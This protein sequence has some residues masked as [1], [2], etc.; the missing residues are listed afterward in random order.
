ML[1]EKT[2]D[3]ILGV[4]ERTTKYYREGIPLVKAYQKSVKEVADLYSI[5]YQTIADGCRRR[6]NLDNIN[7]FIELLRE[8]LSGNSKNLKQLL[9]KNVHEFEH[10]KLDKFFS[11]SQYSELVSAHTEPMISTDTQIISF[12]IPNNISIQL[13]TLAEGTGKS[14]QEL[15]ADFVVRNV[16]EEYVKYLK[17]QIEALP[18]KEKVKILESLRSQI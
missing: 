11:S 17:K 7:E 14:V 1:T 12:R 3:Q 10:Y 13:K 6:L 2:L 9:A 4:L 16:S 18:E 8:W 15:V 5:R